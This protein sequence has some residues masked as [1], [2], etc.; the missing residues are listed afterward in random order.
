MSKH[1]QF[2]NVKQAEDYLEFED[3]KLIT[4]M[5]KMF[6]VYFNG[7]KY[8]L[9]IDEEGKLSNNPLDT[10]LARKQFV[11]AHVIHSQAVQVRLDKATKVKV[12]VKR[13]DED[14]FSST[15]RQNMNTS[16]KIPL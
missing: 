2:K 1:C 5:T 7:I 9:D 15:R 10:D 13:S 6:M 8:D 16:P 11:S 14:I 3:D 12:E 4:K